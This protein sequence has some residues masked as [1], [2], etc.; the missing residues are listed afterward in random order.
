GLPPRGDWSDWLLHHDDHDL[1][2]RRIR[3]VQAIEDLG[4]EV[5]VFGVDVA[6]EGGLS[7]VLGRSRA[8]VAESDG[9]IH[10]AGTIAPDTFAGI[11]RVDPAICERH[12]RPKIRGLLVLEKLL[13]GHTLDFW[14]VVSSLSS[15]LAGLGFAAYAAAN[16]FLDAFATARR[17]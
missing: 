2:C 10:S 4:S 8:L 15:V 11:D 5:L 7:S 13:R 9:V 14:L 3:R 1:T 6:D 16:S 17:W 12:F